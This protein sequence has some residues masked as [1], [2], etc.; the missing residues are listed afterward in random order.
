MGICEGKGREDVE[1]V[2]STGA[3]NC[4]K[5]KVNL[6]SLTFGI[7]MKLGIFSNPCW[8][9]LVQIKIGI[10]L[11]ANILF[12][13]TSPCRALPQ[14]LAVEVNSESIFIQ[15]KPKLQ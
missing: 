8:Y 5:I 12:V 2:R 1:L 11:Y 14:I 15:T 10:L 13:S 7:K 9:I 3:F 6:I 4:W